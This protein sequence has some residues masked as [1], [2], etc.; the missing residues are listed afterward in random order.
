MYFRGDEFRSTFAE[1]GSVRSLILQSVR[2]L[3]LTATATKETLDS[4]RNRLS[5][6]DPIIIGLPPD[7]T[8]IKYNVK[9]CPSMKDLCQQLSDELLLKR[10]KNCIVLSFT[11][12]LCKYICNH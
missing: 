4:V 1:I 6:Q 11:A 2:I 7:R 8:N 10:A 9:D 12:A 3:A 5:L